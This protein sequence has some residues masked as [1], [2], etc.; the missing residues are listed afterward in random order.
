MAC[1][2]FFPVER[3]PQATGKKTPPMP[4][5]DSWSGVCRAAPAGEWR[6]D[7]HTLQQL[8]NFGYAREKCWRVPADGP[9]AVR[10]GISHDREGLVGIYWV[11]E[12]DHLPFAHG[13][14]DYSR[15]DAGFRT[16]HPDACVTRQAQAYV[17][18][19]L[20]RKGDSSRP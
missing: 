19:Y 14:L 18:S 6:P 12:K 3:M 17:S 8:C 20:R 7:P 16:A 11:M 13:P 15:A 1:P 9:D 2:C 4:L 10:F 5:G